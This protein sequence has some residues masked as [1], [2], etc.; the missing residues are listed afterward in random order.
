MFLTLNCIIPLRSANFHLRKAKRASA[1]P[2]E[3]IEIPDTLGLPFGD[4]QVETVPMT[5]SMVDQ[6]V[7]KLLHEMEEN[8]KLLAKI[9]QGLGN[10]GDQKEPEATHL[11]WKGLNPFPHSTSPHTHVYVF[12]SYNKF[13]TQSY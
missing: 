7:D 5:D 4:D 1:F 6:S 2:S 13:D 12:A 9:N 10:K 3:V 11:F 8:D